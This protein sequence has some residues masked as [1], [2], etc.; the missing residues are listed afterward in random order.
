MNT[1]I[2]NL[3]NHLSTNNYNYQNIDNIDNIRYAYL[4]TLLDINESLTTLC[5]DN[6]SSNSNNSSNNN[7]LQN[8]DM[9]NNLIP[10]TYNNT[11]G[12]LP[13]TDISENNTNLNQY[14]NQNYLDNIYTI[15]YLNYINNV[16]YN[17]KTKL[18]K[19]HIKE[20]KECDI[21]Y[22]EKKYFAKILACEHM[23]CSS[24]IKTWIQCHNNCPMCRTP[25]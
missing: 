13:L 11:F 6:N 2:T 22:K 5:I 9:L 15:S 21:C 14:N 10:P 24:C 23:F 18:K 25:I 19:L 20:K 3:N 8:I 16:N 17:N 12:Y 7:Y 4:D 1:N